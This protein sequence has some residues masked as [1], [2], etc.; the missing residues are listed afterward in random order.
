MKK[1]IISVILAV[2]LMGFA[3]SILVL[4]NLGTDPCSCMNLGISSKLGLSFGTWLLM[5]NI[6]LFLLV[7]CLDRSK[8]HYSRNMRCFCC[9]D[10]L[11][12]RK[13]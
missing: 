2:I 12:L 11:S 10:W 13:Y 5:F 8:A 9:Y 6:T 3:L 1:H 7:L 4:V